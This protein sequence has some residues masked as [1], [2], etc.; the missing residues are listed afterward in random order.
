MGKALEVLIGRAT[1]P[2][3]SLT[4][5]TPGSGDSFTVKAVTGGAIWLEN[6]W[7]QEGSAGIVRIRSPRLHDNVQGIRSRVVASVIRALLP[8]KL[9]QKLYSQDVLTVEI[10]GGAAEV[11]AVALLMHYEDLGGVD[12]RLATYDQIAPRIQNILTAEVACTTSATAGDWPAGSAL[13]ATFD[14][15]KANTDYAILGYEVDAACLA[16]TVRGPDT[17]NVRTGGPGPTEPIETRDWFISLSDA[18]AAPAIPVVNSA[19]KAATNVSVVSTAA[20]AT[21]NVNL[22]VAELSPGNL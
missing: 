9:R 11:D 13:N 7:A 20:S 19:N 22:I 8:D 1:N 5:V 6:L 14:L 15:L 4:A 12:G 21:V 18:I 3:A 2:G 17:G 10:A 16:V